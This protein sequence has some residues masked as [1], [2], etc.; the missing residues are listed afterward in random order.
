M[1]NAETPLNIVSYWTIIIPFVPKKFQTEWHTN[2]PEGS[3]KTISR[4]TFDTEE[5]AI[6]WGK[7]HLNG[8]PYS[9]R[10]VTS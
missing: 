6:Q 3:F 8:C 7:D 1:Q 9:L 10:E 4:G 5:D 2:D